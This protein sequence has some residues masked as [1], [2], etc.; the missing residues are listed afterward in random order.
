MENEGWRKRRNEIL[1]ED[2]LKG[3]SKRRGKIWGKLYIYKIMAQ[4]A[5]DW[6]ETFLKDWTEEV[7]GKID[8]NR[9]GSE[10]QSFTNL[11]CMWI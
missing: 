4:E 9:K 11:K 5:V 6:R 2:Q 8:S 10:Q 7:E 3:N 1:L